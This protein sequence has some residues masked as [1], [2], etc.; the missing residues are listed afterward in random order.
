MDALLYVIKS[1]GSV[2]GYVNRSIYRKKLLFLLTVP[3]YIR[4]GINEDGLNQGQ[5]NLEHIE[6]LKKNTLNNKMVNFMLEAL[7]LVMVCLAVEGKADWRFLPN[8]STALNSQ[9]SLSPFPYAIV[10]FKFY[11]NLYVLLITCSSFIKG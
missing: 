3:P 10:S 8:V 2:T 11:S 9:P 4:P 6:S 7:L 1:T 5:P